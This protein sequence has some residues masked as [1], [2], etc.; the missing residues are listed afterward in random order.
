MTPSSALQTDRLTLRAWTHDEAPRLLDMLG[1]EEVTRWLGDGTPWVMEDLE[2]AHRTIDR[3]AERSATPPL[4][5]WAA[6][7]RDTGQ[8]AGSVMLLPLP[9]AEAGE[10]EI[11]WHLHPDS[12]GRG[13]AT[14][15]AEALLAHAFGHGLSEVLAV[16]HVGNDASARV[17]GRLGLTDEGLVRKWYDVDMQL[18]R[19]TEREWRRR[20]HPSARSLTR[21][22]GS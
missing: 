6:E 3:Y 21:P 7:V 16:T 5:V 18:Y 14:E 22:S 15:A 19:I 9:Q 12:W 20:Q 13:Y 10:V 2:E 11:A 4:G 1:R 8:V 17:C